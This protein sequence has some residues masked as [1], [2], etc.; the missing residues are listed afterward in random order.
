[1]E[2]PATEPLA[3][4]DRHDA[5]LAS[6]L[7]LLSLAQ[8]FEACA[9]RASTSGS[10]L[11][12]DNAIVL[13]ALGA[14]SLGRSLKRWLEEASELPADIRAVMSPPLSLRELLR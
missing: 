6:A 11:D 9:A 7:G 14:I 12:A 13:A 8:R 4:A 5:V 3:D 1:M 10:Q 2:T